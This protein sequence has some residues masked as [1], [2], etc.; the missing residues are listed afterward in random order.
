MSPEKAGATMTKTLNLVHPRETLKVP[1]R[2]LMIKCNLFIDDPVLAAAPYSVRAPVSVDDFRQFV[3]ALEGQNVEVTNANIGGLSLLCDEFRFEALSELLSAFRQSAEF[4]GVV[5]MKDP[6]AL[7]RLSALE[8]RLLQRDDDF[9]ALTDATARQNARIEAMEASLAAAVVRLA[10]VEAELE[11]QFRAQES[12]AADVGALQSWRQSAAADVQNV[13][14]GQ[15]GVISAVGQLRAD[16]GAINSAV[17]CLGVAQFQSWATGL[18]SAIVSGL[19]FPEFR[20][21][22]FSLLWRGGRDG[23]GK[24][25]FHS[26]CDGHANTLTLIEDTDGNIFGGFTPLVWES[27][28][29]DP[30]VSGINCYKADPSL[31]S[32]IFTLKNPQNVPARK[33]ALKARAVERTIYCSSEY[34]PNFCDI[35]VADNCNANTNSSTLDFGGNYTND[36]GLDGRTF[37]TG[38]EKF[39]VKE[40]EV[41]EITD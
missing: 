38:S 23:F 15:N 33:F 32:F 20:Q 30:K 28:K 22:R 6:E 41:F 40:I 11:R 2:T 7:L 18:D 1:V 5:T 24:R 3:W 17:S 34:D 19:P 27:R 37:F 29:Y 12:T 9:A 26:R 25:D 14:D 16:V 13:R 8:E 4:R 36:T 35:R 31:K 21:K 10:R 39:Q